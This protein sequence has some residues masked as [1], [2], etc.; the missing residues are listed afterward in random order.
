VRQL[1]KIE[2]ALQA[3]EYKKLGSSSKS[4]KRFI[5]SAEEA[6][7]WPELRRLLSCVTEEK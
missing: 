7:E 2:M 6:T 1:Y 3:K 4:L 5:K